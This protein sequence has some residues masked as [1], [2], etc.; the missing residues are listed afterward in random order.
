ML[1]INS[2]LLIIVV[3]DMSCL[4]LS[5]KYHHSFLLS[6][7]LISMEYAMFA[8]KLSDE[9]SYIHIFLTTVYTYFG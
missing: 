8:E 9:S 3:T 4:L 7:L 5:I 6:I 2:C 1:A